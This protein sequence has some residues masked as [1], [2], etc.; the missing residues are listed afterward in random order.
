MNT[1]YDYIKEQENSYKT[2]FIEPIEG[3]RWGMYE[4]IRRSTL[5]K[6]SEMLDGKS[7]LTPVRNI[8]MPI[9]RLQYRLQSI[10][11]KDIVLYLTNPKIFYKSM[12]VRKYHEKWAIDNKIDKFIDDVVESDVDYG[13]ALVKRTKDK[14]PSVVPLT[15]LAFA[16]QKNIMSSPI[17]IRHE[18][19]LAELEDM[20]G[21]GVK[22]AD[23][24]ISELIVNAEVAQDELWKSQGKIE[25][26]EVRGLMPNE[27]FDATE[28]HSRQLQIVAAVKAKG[29]KDKEYATLF[30]SKAGDDLRFHTAREKLNGRALAW[31]G[32]EEL[33][34]PQV[35]TN[36]SEARLRELL[37]EAAKTIYKTTDKKFGARQS[38]KN[39]RTGQVYYVDG[40]LQQVDNFPR[41][42]A[43]FEKAV[44]DWQS[45]AQSMGEAHNAL[46]GEAPTAGTPAQLQ[47]LVVSTGQGMHEYRKGKFSDFIGEIYKDWV[48]PQLEREIASEH[49]FFSEFSLKELQYIARNMSQRMINRKVIDSV[50][51]G[52][53]VPS[54]EEQEALRVVVQDEIKETGKD[55]FVKILQDEFKGE[56]LGIKF[57]IANRQAKLVQNIGKLLDIMRTV[58]SAPQILENEGIGDLFNQVIEFSGLNP[59]DLTPSPVQEPQQTPQPTEALTT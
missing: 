8:V 57:N 45:H 4:H 16:D 18:M 28:G 22:G 35:W 14:A 15:A 29:G 54:R 52:K 44:N 25:V 34:E 39:S 3:Y 59:V 30:K 21:W 48:L 43:L 40:D 49:E 5:Y 9:I 56:K 58:I 17:G 6:Y 23:T 12:I 53:G 50:L 33:F 7:D 19:T 47:E 55:K 41:N 20:P 32:I 46:R 26:F 42:A 24:T 31:G 38:L 27:W 10:D 11:V 13:G 51:E 37:E 2:G 36:Y 1:L